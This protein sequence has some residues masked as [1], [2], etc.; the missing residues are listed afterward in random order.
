MTAPRPAKPTRPIRPARPRTAL[1]RFSRALPAPMLSVAIL[2]AAGLAWQAPADA[3]ETGAPRRAYDLAAGPLDAVLRA[4]GAQ[5]GAMISFDA[6]LVAGR[7]SPGLR[8]SYTE[9]EAMQALLAGSRLQAVS[10]PNGGYI[11][12]ALPAPNAAAVQLEPV[13]VTGSVETARGPVTGYVAHRSATGTKTDTSLMETPQ[14][15]SVI[16]RAQLRD[17]AVQSVSDALK[18]TAG[19]N[20]D[21]YGSDARSDWFYVRG[22]SADVYWDGLRVPQIAN[23]PGSYAALRVDPFSLERV[24][25][26]RGPASILYGAGNLGGLVNLVSKEPSADPYHELAV[27]YGSH[28][29]RQVR[30]DFTGALNDSGTLLYRFNGLGRLSGTQVRNVSDDRLNLNPSITWQ[31]DADTRLTLS[32]TYMRDVADSAASYGPM[33]GM[34]E[35]SPY[36]RIPRR[37]LTG[38]PDFDRYDKTQKTIGYRFEHRFNDRV[39]FS[40]SVRYTHMD[41][42]YRTLFGSKLLANERTLTRTIYQAR[43]VLNGVQ[44]DNHLQFDARTG[45]LAHKLVAGVDFQR[46]SFENR[47]WSGAGTSLDLYSPVYG[48]PGTLPSKATTNTDQTQKQL[49]MYL[50]DQM[51]WNNWI[52]TLGGR[53][54]LTW[55]TTRNNN[56]GATNKQDPGR[57]TYRAGLLY[58]SPLGFSPYASYSTS[59]LPTLS[60]NKAGDPLQP[61]LGKQYEAGIKYQPPGTEAMVTL[62]AFHLTQTN[63]STVDPNDAAN[64]IQTGEIRTRGIELEGRASLSDRLNM[65]ATYTYQQPEVTRSNGADLHKRPYGV[66]RNM[67][68][69]W[70]DYTVPVNEDY[71]VGGG[72]GVRY[73]G[74]TAGDSSNS[75]QVPSATLVDLALHADIDKHW[76]LQLNVS[77]LFDR[78]YVAGCN[79][80]TQCYY[81]N[82][83]TVLGSVSYKW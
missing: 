56:T 6:D 19:V 58:A 57:F 61:T 76:R 45:P 12:R 41:L 62:A 49:G 69:L 63:V 16:P 66:P 15:I 83:R 80:T 71:R 1:R 43:P 23:R 72:V 3:A 54:D 11:I 53:Q 25:V 35:E 55:A 29:R 77:N 47:V 27:D 59:F 82:G 75:F 28:D 36:G 26:L 34:V 13:T 44:I 17:Q 52:L 42:D 46:Q 38:D 51:R 67:A 48:N 4:F 68:S 70:L 31:P 73:L 14:A 74:D 22:F 78:F 21:P 60:T 10:Q 50:Q 18:Y 39:S 5:S 37:L 32:A 7:H 40:Q 9:P 79:T 65:V 33:V 30:A 8:G 64:T 2:C 24:E 20:A 81:G